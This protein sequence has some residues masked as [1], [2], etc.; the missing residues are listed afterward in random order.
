MREG[1]F[2]KKNKD[3]WERLEQQAPISPDEMASDFT[4]LVDDLGYAKTF[5][6]HSRVTQYINSLAAKIYLGIYRNRKEESNPIIR[7]WKY[8]VPLAIRRNHRTVLFCFITFAVFFC[9]GFFS[10]EKDP[11]FVRQVLGDSYVDMTEKNIRNGNPFDVYTNENSFIMWMVIMFNNIILSFQFFLRGIFLG[12]PSMAG[13]IKNS[14]M[15]GVFE[16]IFHKNGLGLQ[17]VLT[18][19]IHGILEL[20]ALIVAC[21]AGV[22][23]GT[24]FLFPK[25]GRRFEAFRKGAKDG[26]KMIIGLVPVFMVAAFFESYVTR[27][28]KM[29]LPLSLLIL[30]S[31]TSFVIWYFI[32]YPIRLEKKLK[33]MAADE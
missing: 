14:I 11:G 17:W 33:M 30:L 15:V 21:A 28:Y 22:V 32:V 9:V 8:G 16:Q 26:V 18:V 4:K 1:L 12:I 31:T 2:I 13:L 5:Y 19:L 29:P 27:Y 6:P 24:G 25:T 23:L 20:T 7:L 10:S 3:R